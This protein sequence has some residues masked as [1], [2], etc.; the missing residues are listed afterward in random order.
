MHCDLVHQM[1]YFQM[2]EGWKSTWVNALLHHWIS[3]RPFNWFLRL[4]SFLQGLQGVGIY[5]MAFIHSLHQPYIL[6]SVIPTWSWAILVTDV[7]DTILSIVS[8]DGKPCIVIM[9][10]MCCREVWA[11]WWL[12][13]AARLLESVSLSHW[14]ERGYRVRRRD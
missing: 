11:A 9:Y 2:A 1:C 5:V 8:Q 6:S 13:G 14:E 7:K 4:Y 12:H 10:V 3:Q